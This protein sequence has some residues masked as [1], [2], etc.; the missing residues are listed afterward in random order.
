MVIK[1]VR[2]LTYCDVVWWSEE[3]SNMMQCD[4]FDAKYEDTV[5]QYSEGSVHADCELYDRDR[6]DRNGQALYNTEM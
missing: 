4:R 2:G 5:R 6:T 1:S 3:W